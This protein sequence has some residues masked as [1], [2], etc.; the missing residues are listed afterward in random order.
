VVTLT[1]TADDLTGANGLAGRWS[2]RGGAVWVAR[3]EGALRGLD[4][5]RILDL[6]SRFLAPGAARSAARAAWGLLAG[7]GPRFH[8]IDSTLR[9]NPGAE[10]EGFLAAT[11]APWVALLPAY[12][13][14]GRT[15]RGGDLFVHGLRLD[16]SEYA[17]DPLTPARVHRVADLFSGGLCAQIPLAEVAAGGARLRRSLREARAKGARILSFDCTEASHTAAIVGA[18]LAEGCRHYA[19][20]ADLGAALAAGVLGPSRPVVRPAVPW[21]LLAGSVSAVTFG[22]L[23]AFRERGGVWAPRL[24]RFG[25]GAWSDAAASP[26]ELGRLREALRREGV[27]A[28]SSLERREDLEAWRKREAA[29]GRD[30]ARSAEEAMRA[31]VEW[32]LRVAGGP[33]ACGW[34]VTGGHTLQALDTAAGFRRLR[35]DGEILPEVPLG[36]AEGP[37]GSAWICSKPGGFGA[38]DCFNVFS[39]LG[40]GR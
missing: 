8:K 10:I 14:L 22:Q 31:L 21:L 36:R 18:C 39:G 20:A 6:E 1:A 30:A 29:R 3:T 11:S 4:G 37:Q 5:C 25:R 28:L 9:G 15:V 32:A 7:P 13:A 35:V 38:A 26:R 40:D 27:A 24:R 23:R 16:R 17:F 19:G 33:G 12:P 2:G 34:F